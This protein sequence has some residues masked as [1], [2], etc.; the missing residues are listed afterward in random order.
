MNAPH[1]PLPIQG[2]R[3]REDTGVSDT[4]LHIADSLHLFAPQG[5]LAGSGEVTNPNRCLGLCPGRIVKKRLNLDALLHTLLQII[6][7]TFTW[8]MP[9]LQACPGSDHKGEQGNDCNQVNRFA[10]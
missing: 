2:F 9:L 4:S 10:F 8:K 3:Y 5:G 7:V 1:L 6:I